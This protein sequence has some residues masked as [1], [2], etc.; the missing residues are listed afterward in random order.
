MNKGAE[1]IGGTVSLSEEHRHLLSTEGSYCV[2]YFFEYFYFLFLDQ[3]Y[4]FG[5]L[6]SCVDR[7]LIYDI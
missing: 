1:A 7:S 5:P 3:M 4:V 6:H 2:H